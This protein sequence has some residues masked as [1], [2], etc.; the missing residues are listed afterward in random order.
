MAILVALLPLLWGCGSSHESEEFYL[1]DG[2]P[3]AGKG[4]FLKYSCYRCHLVADNVPKA[5]PQVSVDL[6]AKQLQPSPGKIAESIIA[7]SHHIGEQ[8]S[9]KDTS[10]VEFVDGT[11]LMEFG[12]RNQKMTIQELIDVVAY[13]KSLENE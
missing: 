5:T 2:D 12:D 4:V 13:L 11:S 6:G 1:P 10:P 7:P 9:R 8:A 3:L